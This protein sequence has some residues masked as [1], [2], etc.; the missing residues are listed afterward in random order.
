L[1][2]WRFGLM[3]HVNQRSVYCSAV[4]VRTW[5]RPEVA[6]VTRIIQGVFDFQKRIF[7]GKQ[8][9]FRRLGK[10]QQPLALFITCS[11]SR[12]N[13]NLLT[14]T[15]PGE[16]F[17]LRNAGNLVPP[18][19]APSNGEAATIEYA[20]VQLGVRDI[21][22]CGHAKCGAIHGLLEPKA[23]ERLPRVAEW[24]ALAQPVLARMPQ[25]GPTLSPQDALSRA[26]EQNVL[27]Q[28][29]HLR[30]H[31]SVA[32]ATT[33]GKLRLHGWVYDFEHGTVLAHDATHGQFVPLSE[34]IHPHFDGQP[35]AAVR[36]DFDDCI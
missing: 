22:L 21:I 19:D 2:R 5:A 27:V 15:E 13:P 20:V 23:L 30:S 24:L 28:L 32:E 10:G 33:A 26:V 31:P 36:G 3:C 11:D 14:Q 34:A 18:H 35:A 17:I 6:E 9:L 29:Q 1:P 4:N 8:S 7:G 25:G 12:I 16:L